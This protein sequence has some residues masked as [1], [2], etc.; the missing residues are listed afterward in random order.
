MVPGFI[1]TLTW[2][3]VLIRVSFHEE[4]SGQLDSCSLSP[5]SHVGESADN[6]RLRH[7]AAFHRLLWH[8]WKTFFNYS[9][10][11]LSKVSPLPLELN[12]I[13]L[14]WLKT[15]YLQA[16]KHIFKGTSPF[17]PQSSH[18]CLLSVVFAKLTPMSAIELV[19]PHL[20][21]SSFISS[22]GNLF[23]TP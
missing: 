22:C 23:L 19:L 16:S 13:S 10:F 20:E 5:M 8:T 17:P 12:I 9:T 4:M 15:L 3:K 14:Q 7:E 21:C 6:V 2:F 11:K 1:V 18:A